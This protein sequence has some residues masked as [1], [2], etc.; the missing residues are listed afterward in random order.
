MSFPQGVIV[1][2]DVRADL[3]DKYRWYILKSRNCRPQYVQGYLPADKSRFYLHRMVVGAKEGQCVDHINGN[4]LDNRRSNLRIVAHRE[5][6]QNVGLA[7]NNKSGYRGVSWDARSQ[8]WA[9]HGTLGGRHVYIGGFTDR[10][11]AGRVASAWRREH[12]PFS[13]LDRRAAV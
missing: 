8:K 13:E 1:D 11:E 9:A 2:D 12:M 6:L 7:R 4:G 5:N 10:H 3:E